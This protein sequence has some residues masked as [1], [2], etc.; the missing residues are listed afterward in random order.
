MT[1]FLT[2]NATNY[3]VPEE[4]SRNV[5]YPVL[6]GVILVIIVVLLALLFNDEVC[7]PIWDS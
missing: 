3:I 5:A 7:D 4:M 1:E 6:M 2:L